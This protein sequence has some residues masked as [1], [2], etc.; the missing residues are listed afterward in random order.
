MARAFTL[1]FLFVVYIQLNVQKIVFG[2]HCENG[3]VGCKIRNIK[4]CFSLGVMTVEALTRNLFLYLSKSKTLNH[5]AQNRGGSFATGKIIGGIDF[6]SSI[7]VIRDLNNKGLSV[8]VD[9]LGEFVDSVDVAR[10]RTLECVETL[11]T[12]SRERLSSQVSVKMTSLGLDIDHELVHQNMT[13]ILDVAEQYKILVTI[14]MEDEPR[15]QATLD[16][17]KQFKA[18][19]EYVSTVVQSYLY[20][21]E[22]DVKEL[23]ELKATLRIVKG[24]YKESAEVAFPEKKDVDENFKSIVKLHLLNGNFTAVATHDDAM[25]NFTKEFVKE[26]HIPT[27]QFEFQML[28]GMRSQTQFDLAKKGYNMRVYLPYGK[29]WYG[30]CMRRL[31]ER[32]AN[33]AFAFKG[34]VKN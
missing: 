23:N 15:C 14:D 3:L 31:A 7:P 28:Y 21:T 24:A 32:P 13:N 6:K 33:I 2:Q 30:Y 5:I 27:S 17:F 1:F 4:F 10:D 29:D 9:H 25:I 16:L 34:M 18:K 8:T 11:K 19:Y 12:I 22:Q 26:H 20:R